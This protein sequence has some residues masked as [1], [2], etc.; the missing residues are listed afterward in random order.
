ML[1]AQTVMLDHCRPNCGRRTRLLPARSVGAPSWR[2]GPSREAHLAPP[3]GTIGLGSRFMCVDCAH[4]NTVGQH[5]HLDGN[6]CL[7]HNR[8][9]GPDTPSAQQ[10]R[11]GPEHLMAEAQYRRLRRRGFISA[12][13]YMELRDMFRTMSRNACTDDADLSRIDR[14]SYPVMMRT[15]TALARTDFM[16]HFFDPSNTYA[17]AHD[18][19]TSVIRDVLG[20]G[21][22]VA[23]PIALA[24][25]SAGVPQHPGRHPRR[26]GLHLW[27]GARLPRP[28]V[29]RRAVPAANPAPRAIPPLPRRQRRLSP[30]RPELARRPH[31]S[32]ASSDHPGRHPSLQQP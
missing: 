30:H 4:G 21:G 25:L 17:E 6:V 8:W 31:P 1:R 22:G 27:V 19:L 13:F 28:R 2:P 10:T 32:P 7:R 16:R 12:A 29:T 18:T 15:A 11:I 14:E 23:C 20:D 26:S 24:L 5:P 3:R 9:I